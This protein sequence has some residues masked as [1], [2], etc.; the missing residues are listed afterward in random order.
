MT[1]LRRIL[2]T[3]HNGYL[4]SVMAPHLRAAGYDVVGLD[5]DYFAACSIEPPPDVP[6]VRRDLRDLEASDVE[7]FD[8]IVHLGALSNDPIGNLDDTWTEQINFESTVRLAELAKAAGVRRFLFSSS[9]IMYGMSEAA[10]VDETSPLDPKTEYARSKVKAENA[11]VELAGDGFSPVYLRNGTVYGL[12]PRHRFDTVLNDLVA[13]AVT[14][15]KVVVRG[16]GEPWRPVIHIEDVCRAFQAV[17][18]APVEA[19]HNEAFNTGADHLNVQIKDLARIAV[20]AVEGAELEILG[21]G[22]TIDKRTYRASFAKWAATFP[23]FEWKW[24]PATG[25]PQLRDRLV[26]LGVTREDYEGK[27]FVR[28]R[29]LD[30]L[31]EGGQLD[32]SLRWTEAAVP[33]R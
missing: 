10:E 14:T 8:A 11:L 21:Q 26:E 9:C 22:S 16:D 12:S 19:I 28:L 30:H 29:W 4:G 23:E 18:E 32:E 15:G 17:L 27:R 5:T 7:G 1:P 2:M 31:R 13:M 20:D 3:G 6:G 25:G 24:T 33:A